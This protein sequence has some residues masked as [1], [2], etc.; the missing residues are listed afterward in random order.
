MSR[1]VLPKIIL[2]LPAVIIVNTSMAQVEPPAAYSGTKKVNYVRTWDAVKPDTARANFNTS[3]TLQHSRMTTQYVDGLGRPVQTVIKQG[4]M[5]TGDTAL[6]L[7]NALVYDAYGREIYK[8]LPFVANNTS[9]NTSTNDGG[10]KLSPFQQQATFMSAQFSAQSET[11]FYAKTNFETSPMNRP[12]KAMAPGNSWVGASRGVESKYWFNTTTDSVRIWNVTEGP[13]GTFGTYA[14]TG[15]YAAGK[16]YKNVMVDEHGKQVIEFKDNSDKVVLKKVQFTAD[17]DTGTGKGHFGWLCTYYIYDDLGQLRSVIQPEGVKTLAANSWDLSYSSSVL[18]AE[19]CFRYGYDEQNRMIKKKVPGADSVFLVY[20]ARDRLVMTQDGNMRGDDKWLV[21]KYDAL[22]RPTETGIWTSA[23]SHSSHRS[24]SESSTSYPSTSSNYDELTKTFYDDYDWRSSESNPLSDTRSNTYDSYLLTATNGTYPYPQTATV[25]SKR[26][27]GAVTGIK[28]RVLGTNDF[29]YT[30]TFYDEKARPV[31][32]QSQNISGGTDIMVTQYGWAGLPLMSIAKH[33]KA[34][35][36]SQTSIVL[37]KMTYDDLG[38]ATKTE[39]KV[40][41]TKVGSGVMP[42]NYTTVNEME[43]DALGQLKKKKLGNEPIE[44]MN[45]DYNIR[46]WM[47][48]ANRKYIKNS[49]DGAYE[50]HYFGFDLGYDKVSSATGGSDFSAAQYNGNISGMIWKSRGDGVRRKYD[51]TYDAVNRFGKG[52]FTQNTTEASEGNWSSSEVDYSVKGHDADN[53]YMMKY[54]ANGN[55]VSMIQKG[56]KG[57]TGN[58]TIDAL[59]YTYLDY[60]N[61]LKAVTDD[62]NDNDSKLGDFKYDGTAKTSQDYYYDLNGNLVK[63][64]NKNIQTYGGS[65]GIVYNH[66]NLPSL[67]TVK[68]DGSSNKGTIEYTYDASGNKL[69]KVTTEGSAVTTTLYMF[70]NYVNDTLQYIDHEEGR[71]RFKKENNTLHYDYMLK[72]HLGNVRMVLTMEKDTS[73]YPPVTHEDANVSN[74]DIFYENV[75]VSR[76]SRPGS[77]YNSTD[78]GDKVQ[79]LRKSTQ[80]IGAGK[81]LKIMA[82]DKLHIKV[83]YYTPSDWIDNGDAD[84]VSSFLSA[85]SALINANSFTGSF[86]GEGSTVR[87]QLD[88]TGVINSFLASQVGD[89]SEMPKAY[90]NILF[91]DEQFKFVEQNS[92]IIQITTSGSGQTITRISGSAKEALKNGYAYVYVSN[93]SNNLVY[94]DNFQVS[95]ERGPILEETHYYPFGLTMAGISSKALSFGEPTNRLK[96]N[97]KEEQR[98]EFSDGSGLEWMDYGARMYDNQIGRWHVA[99]P[100]AEMGRKW[101]PYNY[102][103]NNPLRFIDPDGMLPQSAAGSSQ[104]EEQQK[105]EDKQELLNDMREEFRAKLSNEE[106]LQYDAGNGADSE[107]PEDPKKKKKRP[108]FSLKVGELIGITE[109]GYGLWESGYDHNNYTTTKGKLRPLP[110]GKHISVQARKFTLRSNTVKGTGLGLSFISVLLTANQIREQIEEGGVQNVDPID[111]GGL[112]VGT[113]G[114]IASGYSVLGFGGPISAGIARFAGVAGLGL[115]AFQVYYML[116]QTMDNLKT[117]RPTYGS[118]END[119]FMGDQWDKG[120]QN[121]QDYFEN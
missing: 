9:S 17:V 72:D 87:T 21:T 54:D 110:K 114:L 27:T 82:R 89:D 48:G 41:N 8:Y 60:S 4:S 64:L 106:L 52:N 50:A 16:L 74:E 65:N 32:V 31:Q 119:I 96:Y 113:G 55:I 24:S 67:I 44:T 91:F 57:I 7:V 15:M 26:L 98:E 29:L 81:L 30:V 20:D 115:Q 62:N 116:F 11:Y 109:T 101:S 71:V 2:L 77:F 79:L 22:N 66:L 5:V 25:Q 85:F 95:H 83:D 51:F 13:A 14:T 111:A 75:D 39:K 42:D 38:R 3:S 18:L 112:I 84:G 47:L 90:L 92:E 10:F 107:D 68:K 69:K 6:D 93:E 105:L 33:E 94:F 37:T 40:S 61:K 97:G 102:A 49:S 86:H 80:A 1:N 34:G 28:M 88:N 108:G 12:D 78:N 121:W 23:A 43:Y 117:W 103:Y 46:G 100:L 19:Q 118:V 70:G 59:D 63:D 73:V 56:I 76:V 53:D 120:F 104:D 99:D 58:A 35:N 36:N 45:Y